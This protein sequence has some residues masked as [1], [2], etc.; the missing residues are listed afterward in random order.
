M[1]EH[2]YIGHTLDHKYKLTGKLGSG[3]SATVYYGQHVG[4]GR[5]VAVKILHRDLLSNTEVVSRF[6]QEARSSVAIEHKNIIDVFDVGTTSF[7]TPYMVM[8]YLKGETL[9]ETMARTGPVGLE[10]SLKIVGPVLKALD[11]A[12]E[13]GFVHR[14]LEAR[15]HIRGGKGHDESRE[16]HRLWDLQIS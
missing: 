15:E 6:Y 2:D 7:G 5:K 13:K 10:D 3:A 12:H 11:A 4:T 9:D 16:D 14:D 8:E 1:D